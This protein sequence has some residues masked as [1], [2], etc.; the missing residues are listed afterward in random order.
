GWIT[1]IRFYKGPQNTGPHEAHLWTSTGTLL[2]TATFTNETASGWQTVNLSQEVAIQAN[3]TYVVSY[4]T[5]GFYSASDNF[6]TS[7]VS[8]QHLTAPS[9]GGNG[10][11]AYGASGLFPNNS[12]NASNY[13][14]DVAFRPQLAA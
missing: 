9:S 12:F 14:V 5:N 1:S 8:N 3:T 11:Y 7:D 2:A 6:F 13:Y 4:H 10:V